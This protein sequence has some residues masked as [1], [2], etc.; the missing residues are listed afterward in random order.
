MID[1]GP[2]LTVF[3]SIVVITVG[4]IIHAYIENQGEGK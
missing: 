2:G 3:L 1:M 4:V